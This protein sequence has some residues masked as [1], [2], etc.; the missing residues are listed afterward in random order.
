[1]VSKICSTRMMTACGIPEQHGDQQ[2]QAAQHERDRQAG[3]H[4]QRQAAEHQD[5]DGGRAH[6]AT[7]PP[8]ASGA[9]GARN[10]TRR[11]SAMPCSE[12]QRQRQRHGGLGPPDRRVPGGKRGFT[13]IEGIDRRAATE[14][15]SRMPQKAMMIGRLT[16]STR[17]SARRLQPLA[18]QI[19]RH[20]ALEM[21]HI[22]T[23]E[24]EIRSEQQRRH[25]QGPR[26]WAR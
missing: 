17:R 15:H 6:S 4:E 20:M 11:N 18:H 2:R 7:S 14:N 1:M 16:S 3:Q 25:F 9:S 24:Q 22:G 10:S 5:Q 8:W 19:H 12:H 23:G 21:Q 26:R 13:V